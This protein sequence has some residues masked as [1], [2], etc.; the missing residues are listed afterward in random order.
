MKLLTP[1]FQC[2]ITLQINVLFEGSSEGFNVL[3]KTLII[4]I[5]CI[6]ASVQYHHSRLSFYK[7]Q[8][9]NQNLT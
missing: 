7:E 1:S 9:R 5:L 8:G 2:W 3:L 6:T 4:S